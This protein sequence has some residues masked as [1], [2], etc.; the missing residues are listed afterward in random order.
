MAISLGEPTTAKAVRQWVE[1]NNHATDRF[2]AIAEQYESHRKEHG[3]YDVYPYPNGQL[4]G[5]LA[6]SHRARRLLEVGC[7]LGYSGCWLLHGAGAGATLDT[8]EVNDDHARIAGEHFRCEGFGDR[9][10]IL[11]GRA[12]IVLPGLNPSYDIIYFDTD[13]AESLP[14]L[15]HFTR[16]LKPGGLLI[17]TNL[18]LGQYAPD[19]PGLEKTAAYRMRILDAGQWFTAYLADGTALSIRR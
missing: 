5:A 12:S 8:I 17:S 6:A 14:S 13:P 19:L 16:L 15:D 7:G 4:L 18:F 11:A 9:I 1:R 10:I 2:R 3:C